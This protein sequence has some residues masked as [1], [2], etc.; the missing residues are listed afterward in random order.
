ME[1]T[2]KV[3]DLINDKVKIEITSSRV[4]THCSQ[5]NI[6]NPFGPNKKIVELKNSVDAQIGDTVK[7]EITEKTR[8]VSILI[9]FGIPV[10]CFLIG[11]FIG[12]QIAGDNLSAIL[13]GVGLI[14]AFVIV[15]LINNYWLKNKPAV[16]KIK[17]KVKSI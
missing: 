2:G 1:E 14:I 3:I 13:G 6:C 15:K 10:L 12:Y 8:F 7:I 4:C 17:E 5:S 9:V 11:I 16:A